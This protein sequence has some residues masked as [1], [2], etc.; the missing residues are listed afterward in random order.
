[1]GF[2]NALARIPANKV[3]VPALICDQEQVLSLRPSTGGEA[4]EGNGL[5]ILCYENLELLAPVRCAFGCVRF[6][7]C[8]GACD[9]P[10]ER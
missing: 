8:D 10:N 2:L 4:S 3:M 1:M 9:G 5:P 6:F 7:D